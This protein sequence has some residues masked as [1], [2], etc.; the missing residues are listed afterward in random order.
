MEAHTFWWAVGLI[1]TTICISKTSRSTK[2]S[3]PLFFNVFFFGGGGVPLYVIRPNLI[4]QR[5]SGYSTGIIQ[6]TVLP[7][8]LSHQLVVVFNQEC[9]VCVA[10]R[11]ATD[12]PN[13]AIHS[14]RSH[15]QM[16]LTPEVEYKASSPSRTQLKLPPH[17]PWATGP[18]QPEQTYEGN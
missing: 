8:W 5:H 16:E 1:P 11:G 6:S 7:V 9:I 15:V 10:L 12:K 3:V 17:F 14:P 18:K 2:S 13:L 4:V